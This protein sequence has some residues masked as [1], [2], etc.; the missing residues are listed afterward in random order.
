MKTF[1]LLFHFLLFNQQVHR[2]RACLCS[3]LIAAG[4]FT[5]SAPLLH[6]PPH[7]ILHY[8]SAPPLPPAVRVVSTRMT[9]AAAASSAPGRSSRHAAGPRT[10]PA[11]VRAACSASRHAVSHNQRLSLVSI[12]MCAESCRTVGTQ[13]KPCIFPFTYAGE[14]YSACTTRDSDTGQP[15]CATQVRATDIVMTLTLCHIMSPGG[16]RGL[17]SGPRLGGL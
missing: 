1:T 13:A 14:Q 6:N 9:S 3:L 8:C 2:G 11:S 16:H 4:K 15:W 17:G 10:S 7:I 12:I 5:V